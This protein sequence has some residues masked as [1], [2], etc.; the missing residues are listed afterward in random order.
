LPYSDEKTFV[1]EVKS[2]PDKADYVNDF[3]EKLKTLPDFLP[4]I[5]GYQ[6][7]PMYAAL[8]MEQGTINLLTRNH[9]YALVVKG[10]ILELVNFQE[11]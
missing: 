6:V 8:D 2:S 10:D 7:I 4:E 1:I 3:I 9:I 11:V 5:K